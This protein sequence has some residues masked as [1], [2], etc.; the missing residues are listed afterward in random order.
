MKLRQ[1]AAYGS[2][3]KLVDGDRSEVTARA[4]AWAEQHDAFYASHLWSPFFI[5]GTRVFALELAQAGPVPDAIVFPVGAGSLLL[6]AHEG[7]RMLAN[8]GLLD[9]VP[10]LFGVQA[11]AC[12]PL[13]EA[14]ASGE[15]EVTNAPIGRGGSVAEGIL[16][17]A[18]PRD[19]EVLEAVRESRGGFAVVEDADVLNAHEGLRRSGVFAEPTAAAAIAGYARLLTSSVLGADDRTLVVLT[20]SGLKAT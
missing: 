11:S 4:Q 9:R 17:A 5:A 2:D 16:V 12:A 15:L 3:L 8:D 6:G 10:R 20:G 19:R 18:P 14:F 13:A 7:F 1:I